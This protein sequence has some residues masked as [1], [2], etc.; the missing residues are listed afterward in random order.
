[1]PG[2]VPALET[3]PLAGTAS[4]SPGWSAAN[5]RLRDCPRRRN[6]TKPAPE[7]ARCSPA[8][9]GAR[10]LT[11]EAAQAGLESPCGRGVRVAAG[12]AIDTR[13]N[14]VRLFG[15]CCQICSS[16]SGPEPG[17]FAPARSAVAQAHR[18]GLERRNGRSRRDRLAQAA[19]ARTAWCGQWVWGVRGHS[20]VKARGTSSRR[21]D[22]GAAVICS[23]RAS[24]S[25]LVRRGHGRNAACRAAGR[26]GNPSTSCF[27][28]LLGVGHSLDETGTVTPGEP[29][30]IAIAP[31]RRGSAPRVPRAT[32]SPW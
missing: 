7:P 29:D 27:H 16:R 21:L 8:R 9:S 31:R 22:A 28:F 13:D 2:R 14:N 19:D 3:D 6:P 20:Q 11:A 10:F 17:G 23:R 32:C 4:G 25:A 24:R 1:V 12:K 30:G 5:W 15:A 18:P 26:P